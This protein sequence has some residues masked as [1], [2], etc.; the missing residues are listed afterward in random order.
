[1]SNTVPHNRNT[2]IHKAWDL[3]KPVIQCGKRHVNRL[4]SMLVIQV[5][6]FGVYKR[7]LQVM[8]VSAHKGFT[9]IQEKSQDVINP[10]GVPEPGSFCL[11][12]LAYLEQ[13]LFSHNCVIFQGSK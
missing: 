6:E 8:V 3:K 13:G 9:L 4:N 2:K 10:D 11:S 12:A 5:F 7:N 1:M